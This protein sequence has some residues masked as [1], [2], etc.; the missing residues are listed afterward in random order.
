MCSENF[1]KFS[2]FE[3]NFILITWN[4][5]VNK[6]NVKLEKFR[7]NMFQKLKV[8]WCSVILFC[9]Q[10]LVSANYANSTI[11][12]VKMIS[13]DFR[14]FQQTG[15][16][17]GRRDGRKLVSFNTKNDNI[18]VKKKTK[19][20]M[21]CIPK[22]IDLQIRQNIRSSQEAPTEKTTIT[23]IPNNSAIHELQVYIRFDIQFSVL[24]SH[25]LKFV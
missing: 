11:S 14:I 1:N 8:V 16:P 23:I 21:W 15:K 5:S 3:Y 18:E 7:K 25:F 2:A 20:L 4:S 22:R 9:C 6:L 12:A 17:I 19:L 24:S 10:L 13:D